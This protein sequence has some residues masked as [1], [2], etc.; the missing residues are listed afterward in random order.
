ML[1]RDENRLNG[2]V[3][4]LQINRIFFIVTLLMLCCLGKFVRLVNVQGSW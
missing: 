3:V 4:M 1:I 2:V